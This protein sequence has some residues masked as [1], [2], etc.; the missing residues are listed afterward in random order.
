MKN[1]DF[2]L[3]ELIKMSERKVT[4]DEIINKLK[5]YNMSSMFHNDC[6]KKKSKVF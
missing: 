2:I 3:N 1:R 5:H 4:I 6:N